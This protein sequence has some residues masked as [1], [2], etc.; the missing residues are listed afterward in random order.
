MKTISQGVT[1]AIDLLTN[2]LLAERTAKGLWEGELSSSAVSTAVASFALAKLSKK[3]FGL[4]ISSRRWLVRNINKDGGW[5]DTPE[6][7][8]NLSATLL[9]RAALLL[10][11]EPTERTVSAL[12]SF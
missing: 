8:S 11:E 2:Y 3:D 7:I 4:T 12:I 9:A 10:D 1:Q 6:S 5:G